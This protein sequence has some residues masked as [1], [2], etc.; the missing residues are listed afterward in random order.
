[1]VGK[2][3]TR[4]VGGADVSAIGYGAMGIS[5]YYGAAAPDEERF[6]LLDAVYESGCTNWDTA[7]VYGDSE[8]L[9]GKWF[10]RTGKRNEIFLATKFGAGS[11]SGKLIDGSPAYVK[12]A[13]NKS[14]EKLG[15][16]YVDLY[17]AHRAD[18]TIPIEHTV[19]AMAE[20]VKEGKVKYLG[21]SE[22]TGETLRRACKVYPISA[23]Q[24][25]YSPFTLDAEDP[26]IGALKAARELGVTVFA[27]SPLG[28]GLLTG[29]YRS[30]EDFEEGDMRRIIPRYSKE[31]FPNVLKVVEDIKQIGEK[32]GVSAGQVTLSWL[33]AQGPD[34]IP[35]PGTRNVKYLNENLGSLEVKLSPEEVQEVREIAERADSVLGDRYPAGMMDTVYVNTPPL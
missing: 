31:N 13:F 21:I 17:Y 35:I 34:I 22:C 25:E 32:H 12:E 11:P 6:K 27:Y 18:P 2:L 8:E 30:P 3:P 5:S 7:D 24:V 10:K 14:L 16:D 4:R 9:I 20:L 19:G 26:K 29:K 33:L 15:V 28:R 23:I 1:M